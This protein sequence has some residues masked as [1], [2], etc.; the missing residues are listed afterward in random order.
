MD[1]KKTFKGDIGFELFVHDELKKII[2]KCEDKWIA[3]DLESVLYAV[4][5]QMDWLESLKR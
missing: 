1:F 2:S 3:Q 4:K 5:F